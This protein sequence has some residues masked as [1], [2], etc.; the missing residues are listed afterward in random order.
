MTS[1]ELPLESC[2]YCDSPARKVHRRPFST[3]RAPWVLYECGNATNGKGESYA[4][5]RIA[6]LVQSNA[7][8]R[9]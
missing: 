9:I 5:K 2:P 4:C 6:E 7:Q 1:R 8:F 3:T